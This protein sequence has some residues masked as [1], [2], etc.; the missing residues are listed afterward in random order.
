[1]A[2]AGWE[3]GIS[4]GKSELGRDFVVEG[5]GRCGEAQGHPVRCGHTIE[6]WSPALQVY[7]D[8]SY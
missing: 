5:C 7:D 3:M 8:L 4:A 6:V 2:S 1:M